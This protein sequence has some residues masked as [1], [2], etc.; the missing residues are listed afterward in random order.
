MTDSRDEPST[1]W[2]KAIWAAQPRWLRALAA[3]VMFPSWLVI[4][5]LIFEGKTDGRA[6]VVALTAFAAIGGMQ[7]VFVARAVCRNEI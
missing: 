3:T 4:A 6:F 1:S 2:G 5:L 7:L